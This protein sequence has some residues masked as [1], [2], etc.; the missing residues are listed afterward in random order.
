MQFTLIIRD[1]INSSFIDK[2]ANDDKNL[3]VE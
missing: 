3:K 2:I 1:L